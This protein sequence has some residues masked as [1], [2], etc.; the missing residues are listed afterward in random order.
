MSRHGADKRRQGPLEIKALQDLRGRIRHNDGNPTRDPD[1]TYRELTAERIDELGRILD[2][3]LRM[4]IDAVYTEMAG[5]LGEEVEVEV[6]VPPSPPRRIT[7]HVFCGE[8][9]LAEGGSGNSLQLCTHNSGQDRC[10][11]QAE[12]HSRVCEGVLNIRGEHFECDNPAP[13]HGWAHGNKAA[14]AIWA[15]TGVNLKMPDGAVPVPQSYWRPGPP[16][17]AIGYVAGAK[18][19]M[20]WV[21]G[22]ANDGVALLG[23]TPAMIS[24]MAIDAYRKAMTDA[25]IHSS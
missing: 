15:G 11:K 16:N 6:E 1:S 24:Q 8:L 9:F 19:V 12:D 22:H 3:L 5:A 10:L 23:C 25:E 21:D 4:H 7:D 20:K 18:A 14:Q 17:T 13:H 2:E